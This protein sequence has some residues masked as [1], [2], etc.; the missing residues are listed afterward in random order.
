MVSLAPAYEVARS[1][2]KT[3]LKRP[4]T[5]CCVIDDAGV[6][7]VP[8]SKTAAHCYMFAAL[9]DTKVW[10]W[11][12]GGDRSP[13]SCLCSLPAATTFHIEDRKGKV[14]DVVISTGLGLCI[15]LLSGFSAL[16]QLLVLME[17]HRWLFLNVFLFSEMVI[18]PTCE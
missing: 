9:P 11:A 15:G 18:P 8:C 14:S 10:G 5:S 17:R 7:S 1:P 12:L 6:S 3:F 4:G 13:P 2:V 16:A